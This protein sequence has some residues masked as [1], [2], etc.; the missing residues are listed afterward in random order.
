M[1]IVDTDC[2][3]LGSGLA[4]SAYAYHMGRHG[5]DVTLLASDKPRKSA[6]SNWAQGGIIYHD[7][8]D[9]ES[10]RQ[11]IQNASGGTANPAAIDALV[12]N[13][14]QAVKRL[15]LDDLSVNFDRERES[16]DLKYTRE[17]GHS[18]ARIIFAKDMTG[19]SILDGVQKGIEKLSNINRVHHAMAIDLLTLSHSSSRYEDRFLPPTVFGAYVLDMETREVFA[20]RARKTILA[21]GGV[22]Q[23]FNHTTNQ[24]GIYGHGPA[25][26]YRVGAR[27]M[28]MEYV[29]F[30]PTAFSKKGGSY[31]LLSEAL[32]GEGAIL[33]NEAGERFMEGQH[34][35]KELAP[36]DFVARS[37]Y[38]QPRTAETPAPTLI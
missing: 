1:R 5:Y 36:R 11:D 21:T 25:M 35:M 8:E 6:N 17:G 22:G 2:L 26:A 29:Q 7:L 14:S 10:L 13:G 15:L 30:H 20:I 4:G 31:L 38:E 18:E 33:I 32:R 24:P 19:Q 28:D 23:L 16:G 37:I 34:P 3:V 12:A 27:L 9:A